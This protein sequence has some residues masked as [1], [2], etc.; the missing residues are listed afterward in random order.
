L[1]MDEDAANSV[2]T[3]SCRSVIAGVTY[4]ETNGAEHVATT[5]IRI[6]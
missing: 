1:D 6:R 3:W 4:V 5:D 2:I